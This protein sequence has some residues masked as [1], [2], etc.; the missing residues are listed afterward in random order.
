MF[1]VLTSIRFEKICLVVLL[2]IISSCS[3]PKNDAGGP[4]TFDSFPGAAKFTQLVPVNYFD[5]IP[6]DS[7]AP[8]SYLRNNGKDLQIYD[9][10]GEIYSAESLSLIGISV[11]TVVPA[12]YKKILQGSCA[13]TLISFP[14]ITGAYGG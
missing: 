3:D 12:I 5:F 8:V 7:T 4:C 14:T 10:K 1:A 9:Y 11:G 2:L 13:P 6:D